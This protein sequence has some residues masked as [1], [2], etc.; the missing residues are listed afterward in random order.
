MRTLVRLS[1][2]LERVDTGLTLAQFR[3][4]ELVARGT[5]RSTHIAG[6]L[7]TSKPAVTVVVEGLVGAGLLTRSSV[8]GDRRV[9]RL[10][11]TPEG[12]AALAR[13]EQAY[14][15]RLSPLLGEISDADAL[16][17][18]LAEVD[19]ALDARW[20]ARRPG[21]TARP[22]TGAAEVP[23]PTKPLAA[24]PLAAEPHPAKPRPA[25]P[26]PTESPTAPEVPDHR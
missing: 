2:L 20:A 25:E 11:L 22:S 16:L 9:I 15:D 26:H 3:I 8:A 24:K 18:Q 19:D 17:A 7:A 4:L 5:E 6:R 10:A 23:H 13:A 21:A 14:R 1:R 12:R